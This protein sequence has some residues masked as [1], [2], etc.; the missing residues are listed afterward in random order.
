MQKIIN[1][2]INGVWFLFL[3]DEDKPE[4]EASEYAWLL[5]LSEAEYVSPPAPSFPNLQ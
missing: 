5:D 3:S 2:F 1:K 4:V